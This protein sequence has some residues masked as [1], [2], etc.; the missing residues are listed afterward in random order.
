MGSSQASRAIHKYVGIMYETWFN[1]YRQ[2]WGVLPVFGE[3]N[4]PE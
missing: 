1:N 4:D 3:P 2:Q